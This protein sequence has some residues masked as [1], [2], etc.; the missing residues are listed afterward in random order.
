MPPFWSILL[1]TAFT[2]HSPSCKRPDG[3]SGGIGG[4]VYLIADHNASSLNFSTTHFNAKDA[5]N[6]TSKGATGR[7]G[8]STFVK[9]PIGSIITDITAGEEDFGYEDDNGDEEM[10][11][12]QKRGR[13]LLCP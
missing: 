2:L 10:I 1:I 12:S 4:N 13:Q 9:V 7:N 5:T 6:G 11:S 8:E 3:G